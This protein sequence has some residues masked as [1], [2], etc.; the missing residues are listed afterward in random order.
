MRKFK[1]GK[2]FKQKLNQI[3]F[4]KNPLFGNFAHENIS[5]QQVLRQLSYILPNSTTTS[6]LVELSINFVLCFILFIGIRVGKNLHACIDI[7]HQY[8]IFLYQFWYQYNIGVIATLGSI[9]DSQLS[10]ESCKFY[11]AGWSHGV[12][13]FSSYPTHP[14]NS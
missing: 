12:A 1:L 9:L 4:C 6:T 3:C 13:L 14:T 11:L 5:K 7:R 10:W 8:Q 2:V